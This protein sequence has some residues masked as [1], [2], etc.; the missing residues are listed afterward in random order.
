MTTTKITDGATEPGT[1]VVGDPGPLTTVQDLGRAG[2]AALGV[3]PSGASDT[4]SMTLANRLVGND[5]GA[6]CLEMTFGGFTGTFTTGRRLALTGAVTEAFLDDRPIAFNASYYA[7]AGQTLRLRS[8]VVGLRSYLAVSGGLDVPTVLGSRS[9][10][11][12]SGLG[13]AQLTAGQQLPLGPPSDTW[14]PVDLAP[15]PAQSPDPI[16]EIT[17]G[18]REDWFVSE[19][20]TQ[21]TEATY[22]V[23]HEVNRVGIR[24]HGPALTRA[25]HHEL[26]P[27]GMPT[28]AVQVP[29]SGQPI[30]FLTDHPATG[31]YPV[32]AV[33]AA[34]CLKLAAQL[35]PGGTVRFRQA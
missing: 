13:P 18:P 33:V 6:A 3:P 25:V 2:H 5:E 26:A 28:G 1:L 23:T 29:P 15:V 14:P 9:T 10:D 19:A 4:A 24:L 35:T 17:P 27:E 32:I 11:L 20:L 30:V 12:M 34:H 16:L 22:T 7:R 31:G 8:P 21:L